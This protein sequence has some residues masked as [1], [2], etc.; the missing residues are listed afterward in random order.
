MSV[1]LL[2]ADGRR[3]LEIHRYPL[4][5]YVLIPLVA[6]VLQSWLPRAL[7][8]W[9]PAWA[10]SWAL[11]DLPLIVTV[12]FALGRRNPIHGTVLGA[13][14]GLFEDA[15]T[16]YPVGLNGI[17]K[18]VVGYLGASIGVRVDVDNHTI[19]LLLNFGFSMLAS[20]IYLVVARFLLGLEIE[21]R[22]LAELVK[23][24]INAGIAGVL[25][26]LL[27]RLRVRE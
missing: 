12:Y 8:M 11:F 1:S 15:M 27:D 17:A 2:G 7:G 21:W 4:I 25:F 20:A 19:R 9:L 22:G 10:S 13:L 16:H 5:V 23:A 3:E 26:P 14:M 18:T 6:L 24:V